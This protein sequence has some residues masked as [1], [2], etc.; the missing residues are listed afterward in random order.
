MWRS[1]MVPSDTVSLSP[2]PSLKDLGL[3]LLTVSRE[4]LLLP[5]L[6]LRPA[7]ALR[8]RMNG[9]SP[10]EQQLSFLRDRTSLD[11]PLNTS[12]GPRKQQSKK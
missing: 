10:S 5:H 8:S 7:G 12:T 9:G 2:Q 4:A 11:R 1:P 6:T 3:I